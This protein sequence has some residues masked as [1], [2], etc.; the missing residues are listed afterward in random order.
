M[1]TPARPST[2]PVNVA[3]REGDKAQGSIRHVVATDG[4][5]LD[6]TPDSL[7]ACLKKGKQGFWLDIENPGD[8]DYELLEKTF[9]FHPLTL[10]SEELTSELQSLT[11]LVCRLL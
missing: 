8:D 11:N 4:P 9:G 10:R 5:S 1:V 6:A 2:A 7:L 3:D